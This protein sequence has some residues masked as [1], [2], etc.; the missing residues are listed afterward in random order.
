MTSQK[1]LFI[2]FQDI[3]SLRMTCHG[4]RAS[5]SIPLSGDRKILPSECPYC[6]KVWF[7][8]SSSDARQVKQ[9]FDALREFSTRG[10]T[11]PCEL[12]LAIE[13]PE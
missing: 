2:A 11:A 3:Q 4:C 5:L 12:D 13:Q 10:S 7:V 9:L 1:R 8:E 6:G